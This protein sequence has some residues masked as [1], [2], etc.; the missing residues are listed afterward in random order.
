MSTFT[1]IC[2]VLG[3][4]YSAISARA[5]VRVALKRAGLR[6][7]ELEGLRDH[8]TLLLELRR[9]MELFASS[10]V[11][12]E[13]CYAGLERLFRKQRSALEQQL[14]QGA[15]TVV[16]TLEQHIVDA[17][18][19]ARS[20]AENAG[21][22]RTDQ[23]KVATAVSELARNIVR[24]VGEGVVTLRYVTR[25]SPGIEI[26]AS[27]SGPGIP[28]IDEILGGSFKS[29]TG[30][31]LGIV[32]CRNLMDEFEIDTAPGEGTRIRVRKYR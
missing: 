12:R 9:G 25:P 31:G 11:A 29:S 14:G 22:G 10:D 26:E 8:T 4:H 19:R 24:Y 23:V 7:A 2:A 6:E 1:N 15:V 5:I 27:D 18:S 32:G 13:D 30:M 28:H 16:I 21:L 3:R 17:R 20:M